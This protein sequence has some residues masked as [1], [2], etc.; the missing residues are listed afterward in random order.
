M[1]G[2]IYYYYSEERRSTGTLECFALGC[3]ALVATVLAIIVWQLRFL[4]TVSG[5]LTFCTLNTPF[6]STAG[7]WFTLLLTSMFSSVLFII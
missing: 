6:C 3:L 4:V 7:G 2:V 1:E 5:L